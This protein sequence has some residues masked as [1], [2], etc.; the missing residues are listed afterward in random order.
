MIAR[1]KRFDVFL[2]LATIGGVSFWGD[3]STRV[4]DVAALLV[5][6]AVYF[7][8]A[9]GLWLFTHSRLQPVPVKT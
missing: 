3:P 2:A 9:I 7:T 4:A 6:W 8:S 5:I 1:L